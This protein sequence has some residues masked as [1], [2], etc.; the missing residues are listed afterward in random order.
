MSAITRYINS[1]IGSKTLMGISG[2]ALSLFV[3]THMAGNL[4]IFVSPEAY[5]YYGYKLNSNPLLIVAEV[6][7]LSFFL[8]HI[9][10]GLT[11]S[12]SN[13]KARGHTRYQASPKH[14]K[15]SKATTPV[16]KTLMYQGIV[17]TVFIVLHLITFK[18]GANYRVTYDGVE[19][20]DLF[21]LMVE[22]FS[23]PGYVIWYV[24]C[25]CILAGHL[26]HG[27]YSSLQTL[28]LTHPKYTPAL[29]KLGYAYATVVTLG[30]IAQPV[31][32]YFLNH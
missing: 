2:L 30:F 3:L 16:S 5:N 11:L 19:M 32:V 26:G 17:L 8:I 25:V 27:F 24:I 31:Y 14:L 12:F 20:R 28:G 4:F 7:L 6:G 10:K 18:Y 21:R 9:F 23:K 29:K 22:V 15:D 1:S 13:L